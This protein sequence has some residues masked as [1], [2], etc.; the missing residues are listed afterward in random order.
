M[1]TLHSRLIRKRW[2][3]LGGE[4]LTRAGGHGIEIETYI[5]STT[6]NAHD[7]KKTTGQPNATPA[8]S[9]PALN[10]A[11][12]FADLT[13]KVDKLAGEVGALSNANR[14]TSGESSGVDSSFCSKV[15]LGN[16]KEELGGVRDEIMRGIRSI[17]GVYSYIP[18]QEQAFDA[19]T[20]ALGRAKKEVR[21]TRFSTLSV[22]GDVVAS[23]IRRFANK[24]ENVVL[25]G[26]IDFHR[27]VSTKGNTKFN[28]IKRYF[29]GTDSPKND[30][31]V[32][33]E[34]CLYL[35]RSV[36]NFE[37]VIIDNEEVFI[38]FNDA[39]GYMDST[40]HIENQKVATK[41]IKIYEDI[42]KKGGLR[43]VYLFGA[44]ALASGVD[45]NMI[46]KVHEMT[47]ADI[48][49]ELTQIQQWFDDDN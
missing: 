20:L 4:H 35:T 11:K 38:H 25:D 47:K 24:I 18:T 32:G 3:G 42:A 36:N 26:S 45:H 2:Q 17:P 23:H 14:T 40:L 7:T 44:K 28:A 29:E 41:F 34:F 19:L 27:I 49:Q 15:S 6:V 31:F 12:M 39:D 37:L 48:A 30:S 21:T 22:A 16:I 46:S 5:R 13:N 43:R 10:V 33:K 9:T 1:L 8:G